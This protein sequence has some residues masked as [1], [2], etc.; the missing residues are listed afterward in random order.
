MYQKLIE[1]KK[2]NYLQSVEIYFTLRKLLCLETLRERNL[3]VYL[4]RTIGKRALFNAYT[5]RA[6][7]SSAFCLYTYYS[8]QEQY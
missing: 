5:Q 6:H 4:V 2:V 7:R 3:C 1:R 8:I